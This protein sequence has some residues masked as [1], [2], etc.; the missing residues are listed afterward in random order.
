MSLEADSFAVFVSSSARA[1]SCSK[2]SGAALISNYDLAGMEE[3]VNFTHPAVR[4]K[5]I[6]LS[7]ANQII[8]FF[9]EAKNN[10]LN[11][12]NQQE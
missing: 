11:N 4:N 2:Q 7:A 12:K 8:L 9:S 5:M 1:Y 6:L 10:H 3:V